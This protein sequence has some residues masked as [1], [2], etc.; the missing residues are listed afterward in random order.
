[1]D[2]GKKIA[3]FALLVSFGFA[4]YFGASL[5]IE[6]R[7]S[8]QG[9]EFYAA[10]P[11]EFGREGEGE[12]Q[13]GKQDGSSVSRG[14]EADELSCLPPSPLPPGWIRSEGTPINYPIMQ[15]CDNDF[16]MHHLP[17]QSRHA[18][19][20]IFLDYRNA[21]DFSDECIL[22]YGHS[23]RAGDMFGSLR[24]YANP[25]FFEAHPRMFI[26]TPAR[27]FVLHLFAGYVIDSTAEVPPMRFENEEHFDEFIADVRSRSIFSS[28]VLP[29]FGDNIVFL[30]TCTAN[31]NERLIIVGFT[32]LMST[33]PA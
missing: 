29:T 24:N 3:I 13:G 11:V 10:L 4:V 15:G 12:R 22:I 28:E 1:M 17:D 27:D 16:F 32:E 6:M 7:V 26:F 5:A 33:S 31:I 20:S 8:R 30:C 2:S 18:W 23:I 14:S 9:A 19:G 25:G 21:A